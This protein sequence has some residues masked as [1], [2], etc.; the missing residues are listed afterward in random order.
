V[1]EAVFVVFVF[2]ERRWLWLSGEPSTGPDVFIMIF[3]ISSME[4][5][6][7]MIMK[8]LMSIC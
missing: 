4:I 1:F 5:V 2:F 7:I 8:K 6:I 3:G